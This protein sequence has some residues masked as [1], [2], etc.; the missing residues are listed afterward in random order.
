MDKK[1]T[2]IAAPKAMSLFLAAVFAA[3]GLIF[4]LFPRG[5][6]RFFNFV[7]RPLG[8]ARAPEVGYQFYLILAAA[9]MYVVARLAWLMFRQPWNRVYPMLLWQAKLASS[10]V[11]FCLFFLHQPYLIYLVNGIIDGAIGLVVLFIYLKMQKNP[12]LGHPS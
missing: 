7:S 5:V 4:L 9:Y 11:S 2:G 3:V 1:T 6:L 10:L 12:N 8:M